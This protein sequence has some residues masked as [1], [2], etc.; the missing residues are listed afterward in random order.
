MV[1]KRG[2]KAVHRPSLG[3]QVVKLELKKQFPHE[4]PTAIPILAVA[5][6]LE[7]NIPVDPAVKRKPTQGGPRSMKDAYNMWVDRAIDGLEVMQIA[8]PKHP[9]WSEAQSKRFTASFDVI[10]ERVRK[11]K[12]KS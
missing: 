11:L 10:E 3:N 9:D 6:A 5:R 1:V 8:E 4:K 2:R 12:K 7:K